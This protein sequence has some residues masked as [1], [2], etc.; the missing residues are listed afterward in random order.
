MMSRASFRLCGIAL[1]LAS[2]ALALP[3][4]ENEKSALP[5]TVIYSDSQRLGAVS[6][7]D[8]DANLPHPQSDAVL[9]LIG[10]QTNQRMAED[11]SDDVD[12]NKGWDAGGK[13]D[14]H[15]RF[16]LSED[17]SEISI[18]HGNRAPLRMHRVNEFASDASLSQFTG[19]GKEVKEPAPRISM[20]QTYESPASSGTQASLTLFPD[21]SA[22]GDILYRP[23]GVVAADGYELSSS[24][25]AAGT[26]VARRIH[27]EQDDAHDVD[28]SEATQG[29]AEGE[30]ATRLVQASLSGTPSGNWK[31]CYPQDNVPR[32]LKVGFMITRKTFKGRFKESESA[33]TKYVQSL[34]SGTSNFLSVR[35]NIRLQIRKIWFSNEAIKKCSGQARYWDPVDAGQALK[36]MSCSGI[37]DTI[38]D[39]GHVMM[40]HD[41]PLH[42]GPSKMRVGGLTNV[43]SLGNKYSV[44][45]INIMQSWVAGYPW[46]LYNH[47]LYHALG[48]HHGGDY[49]NGKPNIKRMC[50]LVRGQVDRQPYF[51]KNVKTSHRHHSHHSHHSHHK[52]HKHHTHHSHHSHHKHHKHHKHA[53]TVNYGQKVK[54]GSGALYAS[55]VSGSNGAAIQMSSKAEYFYI[56]NPATPKTGCV[57]Y[58]SKVLLAV[59]SENRANG[60]GM[61]GCR[62]GEVKDRHLRVNHGKYASTLIIR[63]GSGCVL[64]GQ[65]FY[66]ASSTTPGNHADCGMYG[67]RV[68]RVSYPPNKHKGL[69]FDHGKKASKLFFKQ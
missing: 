61:Y 43:G 48:A 42:W 68:A 45:I 67:C 35:M 64:Y 63:G 59:S 46:G 14:E 49:F 4:A 34:V 44:G 25:A 26:L 65:S 66:L 56:R 69:Y 27:L 21:G 36:D 30:I 2:C 32:Y 19:S 53:P 54:I 31:N 62:V 10:Q 40:I 47:E 60:C 22:Y 51:I 38:S 33:A 58:N 52:H 7:I 15:V 16:R 1:A 37:V 6:E 24:D 18:T 3:V 11:V 5:A 57:K 55:R 28:L 12:A 9:A 39:L 17:R 8:Q 20:S 41:A 29:T 50:T 23:G 13:M